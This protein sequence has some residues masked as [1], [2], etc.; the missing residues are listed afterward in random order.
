MN[1]SIASLQSQF[2]SLEALPQDIATSITKEVLLPAGM[3]VPFLNY[4][5]KGL[6][7]CI[8]CIREGANKATIVKITKNDDV[9]WEFARSTLSPDQALGLNEL[10]QKQT[11]LTVASIF[12]CDYWW[13]YRNAIVKSAGEQNVENMMKLIFALVAGDVLYWRMTSQIYLDA[14]ENE[15]NEARVLVLAKKGQIAFSHS[16]MAKNLLMKVCPC[17]VTVT[18]V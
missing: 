13:N 9:S 12:G 4:T 3:S 2:E 8:R 17:E 18:V 7:A 6:V 1:A 11:A 14:M 5:P 16:E 10:F 15:T